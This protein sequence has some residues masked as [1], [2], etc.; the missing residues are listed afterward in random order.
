MRD[1]LQKTLCPL[2]GHAPVPVTRIYVHRRYE[3]HGGA[4]HVE[5]VR[6]AREETECRRCGGRWVDAGEEA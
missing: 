1:A 6:E 2:L 4:V 3:T 5:V